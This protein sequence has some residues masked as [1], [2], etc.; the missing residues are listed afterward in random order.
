MQVGNQSRQ[1]ILLINPSQDTV[2]VHLVP[3]A[4]Y[5]NPQSMLHLLPNRCVL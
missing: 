3:L 4:T 2:L 1:E 5:P